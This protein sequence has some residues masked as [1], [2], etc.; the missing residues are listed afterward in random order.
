MATP[1]ENQMLERIQESI[2]WAE[3]TVAGKGFNTY[4]RGIYDEPLCSDDTIDDVVQ[5]VG[6]GS[7]EGKPYWLCKNYWGDY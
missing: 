6:Y 2:L 7:E 3:M 1:D 5:I 4:T